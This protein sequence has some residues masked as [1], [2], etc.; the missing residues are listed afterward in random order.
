MLLKLKNLFG[1]IKVEEGDL[2]S[3]ILKADENYNRVLEKYTEISKRNVALSNI[4]AVY[5]KILEKMIFTAKLGKEDSEKLK[6]LLYKEDEKSVVKFLK[7][8]TWDYER[9]L[10]EAISEYKKD[11]IPI[12]EKELPSKIIK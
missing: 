1:L 4:R 6:N 2:V 10:K 9:F 3:E 7:S 5:Y 12:M 8:K 11:I